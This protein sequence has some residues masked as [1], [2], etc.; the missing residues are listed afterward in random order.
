MSRASVAAIIVLL[1]AFAVLVG[2]CAK[3]KEAAD[4]ARAVGQAAKV[5]K[6]MEDGKATIKTDDGEIEIEGDEESGTMTIKSKD[7]EMEIT[8]EGDDEQFK[9]TMKDEEGKETTMTTGANV[10]L[11]GLEVAIY[12]GAETVG[13]H[14]QE[15]PEGSIIMATLKTQDAF[16]IGIPRIG[17][18]VADSQYGLIVHE[19]ETRHCLDTSLS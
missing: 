17:L 19:K 15:S 13:G 8:S 10:D 18:G 3:A 5:A 11:S 6:D 4:T 14:T 7:G 16:D 1:F 9:M 12:P 2:G